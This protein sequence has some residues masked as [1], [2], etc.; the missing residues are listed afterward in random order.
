MLDLKAVGGCA[1]E[2]DRDEDT[3][4]D[5]EREGTERKCALGTSRV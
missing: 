4:A 1:E 3:K 5:H 2:A